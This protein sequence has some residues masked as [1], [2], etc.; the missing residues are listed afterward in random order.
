MVPRLFL[1][2]SWAF[3]LFFST[4]VCVPFTKDHYVYPYKLDW[5][6]FGF[7]A[8][9][10]RTGNS[11]QQPSAPTGI[12]SSPGLEAHS[13]DA[14][15]RHSPHTHR[16]TL[17]SDVRP[18]QFSSAPHVLSQSA[19]DAGSAVQ[20]IS[21]GNL[22]SSPGTEHAPLSRHTAQNAGHMLPFF[23]YRDTPDL[24]GHYP[25][26]SG[27]P[28]LYA[29]PP[30][31]PGFV[32]RPV[33]P[34]AWFVCKPAAPEFGPISTHFYNTPV[35]S[36]FWGGPHATYPSAS[37]A[38]RSGDQ[39]SHV[40]WWFWDG[41]SHDSAAAAPRFGSNAGSPPAEEAEAFAN[42]FRG[43][44]SEGPQSE[45]SPLLSSSDLQKTFQPQFPGPFFP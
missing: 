15:G 37:V 29:S 42:P 4:G 7:A 31:A 35:A 19:G 1:R 23:R 9:D 36:G 25:A 39:L 20:P 32:H 41:P 14:G 18:D 28:P 16:W 10:Q 45:P 26:A 21:S 38:P 8:K 33:H 43:F 13:V 27:Y 34:S 2:I 30:A 6:R 12:Q 22:G 17:T 24:Y 5:L 11:P 40:D 3:L 44:D